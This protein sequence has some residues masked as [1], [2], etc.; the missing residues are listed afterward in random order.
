MNTI[1]LG[2]ARAEQD[3]GRLKDSFYESPDYRTLIESDNKSIVVGR[4]GVGKSALFLKLADYYKGDNSIEVITFA[5]E[6]HEVL[7]FRPVSRFFGEKFNLIRAGIRLAFRFALMMQV[8]D[9]LSSRYKYNQSPYAQ[10]LNKHLAAWRGPGG[11]LRRLKVRIEQ[12]VG[13]V[14]DAHSRIGALADA[15]DISEL[16]TALSGVITD[17]KRSVVILVDRLDEGY[18]PDIAGVGV[19]DGF[20]QAAIDLRD[21]LNSCRCI[22]F[23]RDN[24]YRAVEH[25]DQDFSRNL[26]QSVLRLHW[27]ERGLLNFAANRIRLAG[28]SKAEKSQKVWDSVTTDSLQGEAGFQHCLR[29]TLFRPRDLLLLLNDAFRNAS[30]KGM[31]AISL[32]E[33]DTSARQISEHR[34][35]D[36]IKEYSAHLP[37]LS[38]LVRNFSDGSPSFRFDDACSIA[39]KV[40]SDNYD[41]PKIT[42]EFLLCDDASEIIRSLYSVGFI[43]LKEDG[44]ANN[45]VRLTSSR[46]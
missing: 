1:Y 46:T 7:A 35:T 37:G 4:R 34:M 14:D 23:L 31:Y 30:A 27:D 22:V 43:G 45:G 38:I 44:A 21:K 11:V 3:Y 25:H 33:I 26:E 15:L 12:A 9:L 8:A 6:E 20:V 24:I 41:D 32:E 39:Q 17:M 2:D 5:P 28:A 29:L 13:D 10:S 40:I 16:E 42:Q 36:L 18:E 19:V